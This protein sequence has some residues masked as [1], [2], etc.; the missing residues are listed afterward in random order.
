[1]GAPL[2]EQVAAREDRRFPAIRDNGGGLLLGDQ[3]GA[4]DVV[5]G[6][7]RVGSTEVRLAVWALAPLLYERSDV[8]MFLVPFV[9]SMLGGLI[10][11]GLF[12]LFLLPSLVMIAEA[13]R[14]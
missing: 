1:V 10:F 12:I 14:E 6:V 4:A 7:R 9:V 13:G 11:S 3:G 2:G 5:A 8:L